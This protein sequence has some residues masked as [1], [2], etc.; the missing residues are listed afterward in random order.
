MRVGGDRVLWHV[1]VPRWDAEVQVGPGG[2][3]LTTGKLLGL[4][5]ETAAGEPVSFE[6]VKP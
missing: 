2:A 4:W 5:H 1:T 3:V 6:L